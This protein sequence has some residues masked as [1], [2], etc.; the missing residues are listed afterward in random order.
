MRHGGVECREGCAVQQ[1][2]RVQAGYRHLRRPDQRQVAPG[3]AEHLRGARPGPWVETAALDEVDECEVRRR[4][5]LKAC[6]LRRGG[7]EGVTRTLPARSHAW[8]RSPHP[9]AVEGPSHEGRLQENAVA[10]KHIEASASDG[11]SSCRVKE[12]ER[13]TE[14]LV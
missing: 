2:A 13:F 14:L 12:P 7:W 3:H 5:Q 10:T 9:H 4:E 1:R 11:D 8:G 6:A